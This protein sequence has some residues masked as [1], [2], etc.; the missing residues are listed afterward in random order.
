[1]GK[2]I[3]VAL[4]AHLHLESLPDLKLPVGLDLGGLYI[5]EGR[6]E[7]LTLK[8]VSAPTVTDGRSVHK[9]RDGFSNV[10]LVVAIEGP[11]GVWLV[12]PNR[13]A[14]MAGPLPVDQATRIL[15]AGLD[16]PSALAARQRFNQLL[17][18]K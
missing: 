13:E 3:G 11:K 12:G 8:S 4:T 15:Q 14:A 9:D 5:G 17:A 7:V 2:S 18:A 6:K 10:V 1:M 16:E